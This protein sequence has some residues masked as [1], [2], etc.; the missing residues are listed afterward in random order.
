MKTSGASTSR[1]AICEMNMARPTE[2]EVTHT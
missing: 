2:T 1:R